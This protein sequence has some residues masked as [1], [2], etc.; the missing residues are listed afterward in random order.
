MRDL[1]LRLVTPQDIVESEGSL[2]AR[3]FAATFGAIEGSSYSPRSADDKRPIAWAFDVALAD[4]RLVIGGSEQERGRVLLFVPHEYAFSGMLYVK[5]I[6]TAGS[7]A[8]DRHVVTLVRRPAD[9]SWLADLFYLSRHTVPGMGPCDVLAVALHATE[10]GLS[11]DV[12]EAA[13]KRRAP[14]WMSIPEHGASHAAFPRWAKAV[15]SLRRLVR[16]RELD[17]PAIIIENEI[18][19][20]R[21]TWGK[22]GIAR[23]LVRWPD[24]LRD[25]AAELGMS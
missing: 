23:E 25:V 24:D 12:V 10:A 4:R 21:E 1:D 7:E 18:A 20:A 2:E 22:D 5:A 11:P 9:A 3:R 13:V 16:L 6:A 8:I 14:D 15:R 17:A 19:I